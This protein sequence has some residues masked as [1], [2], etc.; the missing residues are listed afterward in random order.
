MRGKERFGHNCGSS[1]LLCGSR[2]GSIIP[3][4]ENLVSPGTRHSHCGPRGV[5]ETH[6]RRTGVS[7][8]LIIANTLACLSRLENLLRKTPRRPSQRPGPQ[9]LHTYNPYDWISFDGMSPKLGSTL[10]LLVLVGFCIPNPH[11][12]ILGRIT[13]TAMPYSR[14]T[15]QIGTHG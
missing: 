14:N 7:V 8:R 6:T 13:S 4:R 10:R 5:R 3:S 2:N 12:L 11:V 9:S 15:Q 1:P